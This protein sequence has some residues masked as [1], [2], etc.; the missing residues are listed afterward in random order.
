MRNKI[1]EQIEAINAEKE[2]VVKMENSR[3]EFF[4]SVTHE[5]K[6]PLTA[7]SGYAQLLLSDM[8]MD[9]DF[10]NGS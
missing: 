7:I 2:K 9:K 5:L 8:V 10:N 6:T 4:N 3:R 1:K